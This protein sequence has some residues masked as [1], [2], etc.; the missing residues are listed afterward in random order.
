MALKLRVGKVDAGG[1]WLQSTIL[2]KETVNRRLGQVDLEV[3]HN[4]RKGAVLRAGKGRLQGPGG[5]FYRPNLIA[6]PPSF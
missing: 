1:N 6:V 3:A 5:Y 4:R 2:T